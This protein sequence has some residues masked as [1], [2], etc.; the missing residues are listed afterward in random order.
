MAKKK[1]TAKKKGHKVIVEVEAE[2]GHKF[3]KK[4]K[5]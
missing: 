5:R 3:K 4:A 2:K 1:E